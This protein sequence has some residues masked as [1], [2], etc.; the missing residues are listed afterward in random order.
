VNDFTFTHTQLSVV[1]S[2]QPPE[3]GR[4]CA[5]SSL[6]NDRLHFEVQQK[7]GIGSDDASSGPGPTP[8]PN[9][10][11][12]GV[13]TPVARAQKAH[14]P[15]TGS[16]RPESAPDAWLWQGRGNKTSRRAVSAKC[17]APFPRR[18]RSGLYRSIQT[19]GFHSGAAQHP[20]TPG[21]GSALELKQRESAQY[22]PAI[23]ADLNT[24]GSV[25]RRSNPESSQLGGMN[26]TFGAH[27]GAETR[28]HPML[29]RPTTV[30][31]NGKWALK[32]KRQGDVLPQPPG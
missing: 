29:V 17:K 18:R 16:F 2:D 7:I 21:Q 20:S 22:W 24:L 11:K 27:V 12:R 9:P 23:G 6:A 28:L 3:L 30:S 8:S 14:Q 19:A 4:W 5:S 15:S 10:A 31:T 13:S 25:D 26:P 1:A 32:P